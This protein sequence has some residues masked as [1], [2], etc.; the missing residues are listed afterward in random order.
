MCEFID[1][2]KGSDD[3]D[4]DKSTYSSNSEA[5]LP[6]PRKKVKL[7]D[8]FN[9]ESTKRNNDDASVVDW[10]DV[11]DN[12]DDDSI[13]SAGCWEPMYDLPRG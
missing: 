7:E 5:L 9:M 8:E 2:T 13:V 10:V 12:K 4:N 6:P 3:N 1:L 11:S